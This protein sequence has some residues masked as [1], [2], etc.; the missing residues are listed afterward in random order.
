MA[1]NFEEIYLESGKDIT[2]LIQ[3]WINENY[4]NLVRQCKLKEIKYNQTDK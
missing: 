2:T 1:D 4:D 3:E